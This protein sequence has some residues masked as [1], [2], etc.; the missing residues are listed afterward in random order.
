MHAEMTDEALMLAYQAGDAAAFE[1]LYRRYRSRLY[2]Y[3]ARQCAAGVAEELSQDCWMRVIRAR[4][5]Y[6]VSA[7]FT[8]WL[9]RIAHNRLIDHYRAHE[10]D[11]VAAYDDA[12]ILASV[13]ESAPDAPTLRPD[14]L[15]EREQLAQRLIAAIEALPPPQREAFLLQQEGELT[16]SEIAVA[17]GVG[18]ETA[19]SRLRYALARLRSSLNEVNV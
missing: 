18:A 8:T 1:L 7:K 15:L 10:R 5:A 12:E 6:E 13:I 19:K 2:R 3:L 17:T 4:T 14:S 11:A 16:V 9:F